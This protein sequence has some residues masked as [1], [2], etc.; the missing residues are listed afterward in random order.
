[1][2]GVEGL[3]GEDKVNLQHMDADEQLKK[4][5]EMS[6]QVG[7]PFINPDGSYRP[8]IDILR[9]WAKVWEEYPHE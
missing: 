4:A 3:S 9:D 1:M 5:A 8:L 7:V 6:V 2:E